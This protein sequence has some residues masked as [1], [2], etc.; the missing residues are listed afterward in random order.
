M[1]LNPSGLD[2]QSFKAFPIDRILDNSTTDF[3]LF[4][5]VSDHTVLYGTTGYHWLREELEGLLKHGHTHFLIRPE[6]STKVRMYEQ[7]SKL[8]GIDNGLP[9]HERILAIESVGA[10]FLRCLYAGELSPGCVDKARVIG[11]SLVSCVAE[12]PTCVKALNGL[13]EHDYYTYHHSVRVAS[14][15]VAIAMQMGLTSHDAVMDM[16][17]GSIFH[18]IGKKDVALGILNKTGPLTDTEWRIMRSHPE[19]GYEKVKLSLLKHVPLEIILHHHEKLDGSGYPHGLDRN[20]LLPE[21]QIATLAD[22]FDALTSARA[23]QQ[24]RSRYEALDFIKHKMVGA[25]L[26]TDAFS[27]LISCLAS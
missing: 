22:I 3:D 13:Q 27:A 1:N 14:Y 20:S 11:E 17:L 9:P 19:N 8:P 21:V 23:Y 7:L 5:N 18:D 16:A 6:D 25:K 26:P 12:D 4:I 10:L 15:S 2:Y 24:K